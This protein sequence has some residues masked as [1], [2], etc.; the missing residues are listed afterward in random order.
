ME[1]QNHKVPLKNQADALPAYNYLP[2]RL[3]RWILSAEIEKRT[4]TLEM[5]FNHKLL[6]I[7]YLY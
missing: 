7:L 6:L 5:Q 1:T 3:K 2:V 4:Q